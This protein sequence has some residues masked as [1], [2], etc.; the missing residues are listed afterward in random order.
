MKDHS[1][2]FQCLNFELKVNKSQDCQKTPKENQLSFRSAC[3]S[4]TH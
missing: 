4:F 2:L 3:V 1:K